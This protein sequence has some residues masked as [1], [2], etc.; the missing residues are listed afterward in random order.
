MLSV[1]IQRCGSPS[2]VSQ[3]LWRRM[4]GF[5]DDRVRWPLQNSA[6]GRRGGTAYR[7]AVP[8]LST[9]T[10]FVLAAGALVA[11]PGPNHCDWARS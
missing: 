7:L 1:P 8:S 6:K 5:G 2:E 10:L 11:I 9:L 3:L 4:G